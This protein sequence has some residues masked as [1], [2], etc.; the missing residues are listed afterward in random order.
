MNL[1][2]QVRADFTLLLIVALLISIGMACIY[3]A[4]QYAQNEAMRSL[5]K[6]QL[7]WI[8]LGVVVLILTASIPLKFYYAFSYIIYGGTVLLLVYLEVAGG[9]ISKG[10]E[11]WIS[12]GG[13][14]IQPSELMKIGL[15]FALARYFSTKSISLEKPSSLVVPGILV[16]IP[17]G[18][19][20][21]QPDLGT[22]MIMSITLLP[23]LFWAG[24]PALEIF[25]LVSPFISLILSF[26][27]LPWGIYFLILC[28]VLYFARP[29]LL[30]VSI[31][32]VL[33]LISAGVTAIVWNSLH[34]YQ[35]NRILSFM[36][37]GRDPI[38][39][40]YQVIQ[41]KVAIGSG[42]LW[43]KGFLQG[44]QTKLSFLPEQHTDF[45]FSVLGEQFGFMGALVLIFLIM[46]FIIR[47]LSV[48]QETKNRFINLLSIGATSII[49]FH[50]IINLA[51]TLGMMPVTGIPLPFL[52]YGG[53][54]IITCMILVGLLVCARRSIHDF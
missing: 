42:G 9:H 33:N 51:M 25:L 47:G 4:T 13:I 29:P 27:V 24:M 11:R 35:K 22:A 2:K 20:L 50:F 52:S 48:T 19:I 18:L 21:K 12:L 41:S 16:L 1:P 53:S 10:A 15:L 23:M 39:A 45:I 37:P 14:K 32:V 54:F 30:L 34:D 26:N 49:G 46:F 43:G 38:G 6:T 44:T 3:S 17:F 31:T 40:G 28:V 8:A 7:L 36:D 5:F